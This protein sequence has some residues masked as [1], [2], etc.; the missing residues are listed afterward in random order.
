MTA[1]L[2]I[3][4]GLLVLANGLF[5]AAEFALVRASRAELEDAGATRDTAAPP[6]RSR[7]STTSTTTCRRASSGSRWPRSGIGF[8]GEPA[9]ADLIEPVFDDLSTAAAGAMGLAVAYLVAAG[10]HITLGEQVPK[11]YSIV[12]AE[13]DGDARVP[14]R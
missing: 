7:S 10:A 11:V 8:L 1:L 5:V 6:P 3:A 2:L 13:R 12:H 14:G 9:L 4:V